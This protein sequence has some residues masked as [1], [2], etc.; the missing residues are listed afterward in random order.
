MR[1]YSCVRLLGWQELCGAG[2]VLVVVVLKLDIDYVEQVHRRA[3][4][5]SKTSRCAC[6][7]YKIYYKNR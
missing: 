1:G 3:E 2:N 4:N 6:K 7:T 5:V